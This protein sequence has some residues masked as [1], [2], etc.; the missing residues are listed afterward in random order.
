MLI[1]LF[2][3]YFI[4]IILSG[5]IHP[6]PGPSGN[7]C[8]VLYA[9]IRGLKCNLSD[10]TV[11]SAK[12]DI[13]LCS[14]T[15]VSNLRHSSEL[16]IPNFKKPILLR[17][18]F[19]PRAQGMC[20]YIRS[21]FGASRLA[22][23]ECGCHEVLVVRVCGRFKNF[24]LFSL[25]RNPDLDDGIFD[26]LLLSMASIQESDPKASFLFVGDVNAHHQQW[27]NSV[28]ATDVHGRA[29]QDFA[30]L[31]GCDQ[32]VRAPTH[33][34]GNSLDLA[35]TDAP[36]AVD[37]KVIPP[38]GSSD[39]SCL[40]LSVQTRF[41]FPDEILTRTVFL[42][43]RANWQGIEN[44]FN[45]ISWGNIFSSDCP[46]STLN[47]VLSTICE[48]RI[49][50]KTIRSRRADKPWFNDECR[51]I[52]R[53]K[54]EAFCRWSR[55]RSVD[56]WNDYVFLRS[57]S[58]RIYSAAQRSY[59]DHLRDVLAGT[60]QP[61]SWWSALK[62]S[63][64]GVD[65]GLPPLSLPDGSLCH[66]SKHKADLLCNI[67]NEKQSSQE[68][69]LPP[70][71]APP[72]QLRSLAFRSSELL[73]YLNDLDTFGGC[74]PLGFLPIF[75][76][77]IA[78]A[79][80]PKLAVIFR[81]LIRRGSFPDCWRTAN[82]TPIPKGSSPSSDPGEYRPISITPVLSKVF[83]RLIAKRLVRF[84]NRLNLLPDGQFGF[85]KGLSTSDA[86][87]FICHHIQASLDAGHESRIVSLDFSSAFDCV[88]HKALIFKLRCLGIGER[89]LD[90]LTDFL[91]NRKQRVSV[92]GCFSSYSQIK[93][94]VPQGSVLG[95]LLFIIYTS[96]MWSGIESNMISYAD[97]TT[98]FMPVPSALDRLRIAELLT[99][100]LGR[101]QSWCVRWGMRLNPRKSHSF[102]IGRS[103][104]VRPLHPDIVVNGI[105]VP[106]CT[107][108]KLLGVLFDPKL[109]FELHL[110]TVASSIT[111]RIG[112]MRKCRQIYRTDSVL[113]NCFYSF[114]LP[115]FEY[116][117][118]V[119]LS[120]CESNLRLL[121]RA[122]NQIRFLLPDLQLDLEHR[123]LVGVLTHFYKIVSNT[124]HP[125][126]CLLPS[127]S[128]PARVTRGSS[129]MG[130]HCFS[131]VRVNTS[132]FSRTFFPTVIRLWNSL[133]REIVGSANSCTF[134]SRLNA[135]L[136]SRR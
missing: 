25:Y 84:L 17:R 67:F 79:L 12:Y 14:E 48:R 133:P 107:S 56:S 29:A 89:V 46:V 24:Y 121:D 97:D 68:L 118:S 111:Q 101:I 116:C 44:D 30:N 113:R 54:Q 61:H 87:L 103:R 2:D 39:H 43:S 55:S 136:L 92:D 94:G 15:L 13:I 38:L 102:V 104:T 9:N 70:S 73:T 108:L 64:F 52:Q 134:K 26:C 131:V 91:T 45:G 22:K 58:Q 132:Q 114:L 62:Q 135:F 80:A 28:S 7:Y 63:L 47:E 126:H 100:D 115:H 42:K 71:C 19:I 36:A 106:N 120:A 5:D 35:L 60:S 81:I 50:R 95:P 51:S 27:L 99:R 90:I 3:L 41:S 1:L 33:I 105:A 76:K 8:K 57:E 34:S 32:L 31:S 16:M 66:S 72:I 20:A 11:L 18:N 117:H 85:R 37:V 124:G 98:L 127:P 123:R 86:L 23:F 6:N 88:N 83:E 93:S 110:R 96:D 65:S 82:V 59:N 75:Y 130:D 109:T 125:L 49:P 78:P 10:L 77:K 74:D 4:L 122:F 69:P 53:S 129:L 128:R 119:F 40:S 21:S 112:L